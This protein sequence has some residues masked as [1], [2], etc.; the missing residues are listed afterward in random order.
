MDIIGDHN[1]QQYIAPRDPNAQGTHGLK[2]R[3]YTTHPVGFYAFAPAFTLP[4][5]NDSDVSKM[6]ADQKAA[7]ARLSDFRNVGNAG[8]P[9]PSRDQNGRGY[10]WAHSGVS[11]HLAAR[12]KAGLPYEDLSAYA[13]ACIIKG[14]ADEGG[15]GAEGVE[16][17][18]TRGCP[19]SKTWPQQSTSRSNDKPE[20]WTEAA[21]FKYVTWMDLD[22][23]GSNVRRQLITALLHNCPTVVDYNWWSH[24][25]CA[26]DLVDGPTQ[27]GVT[28][29][30]SGKLLE[31]PEFE[32]VWGVN[33]DMQGLGIII[34]NSWGDSWSENGTGA[35]TGSKAIPNGAVACLVTTAAA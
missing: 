9:I 14:Y 34:W 4:L 18:A 25:I 3:D 22:D 13:V 33:T 29:A 19:T 1:Y 35:L 17:Q 15:W 16:F 2:P 20:T 10:C 6:I 12:A 28:R 24:S 31:L 5:V 7:G 30:E 11:A 27:F 26:L 32:I 21:K 8:Q 23:S